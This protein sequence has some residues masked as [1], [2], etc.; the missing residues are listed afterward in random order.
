MEKNS[1]HKIDDTWYFR[2]K[3]M[4]SCYPLFDGEY[5]W[6]KIQNCPQCKAKKSIKPCIWGMPSAEDGTSGKYA[7]MGCTLEIPSAKWACI[8][9]DYRIYYPPDCLERDFED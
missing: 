9:C 2:G 8:K 7:I 5:R 1:P 3:L 6:H 4:E